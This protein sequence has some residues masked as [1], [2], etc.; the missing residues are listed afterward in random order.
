V[1]LE[2]EWSLVGLWVMWLFGKEEI[3]KRYKISRL[4]PAKTIRAFAKTC[5]E[6]RSEPKNTAS[7]LHD[8]LSTARTDDYERKQ[9]KTNHDYPRKSKR[10][11][12]GKPNIQKA[13][14]KKSLANLRSRKKTT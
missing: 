5:R 6:Y 11:P 13:T 10:T 12:T 1:V 4:S 7:S 14:K 2:L 3:G 8:L 9:T